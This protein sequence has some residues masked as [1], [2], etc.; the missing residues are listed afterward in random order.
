MNK[1]NLAAYHPIIDIQNNVVF[2]NNGNVVLCY[3]GSLPEIYSLSEKDFE[4]MHGSWFQ[5]LKSLPTGCVVHKQD[6]YIKQKYTAEQLPNKTLL[7][8]L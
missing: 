5:A 2:A 6:V 8:G 1:I 3:K 4:D 7:L